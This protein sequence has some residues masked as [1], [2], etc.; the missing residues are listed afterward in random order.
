MEIKLFYSIWKHVE[1]LLRSWNLFGTRE[2]I[3]WAA[4]KTV[5]E[6]TLIRRCPNKHWA[7]FPWKSRSNRAFE[8]IRN[9]W[10]MSSYCHWEWH[11][12]QLETRVC[13]DPKASY[14]P[15]NY[16]GFISWAFWWHILGRVPKIQLVW[17][18]GWALPARLS[19]LLVFNSRGDFLAYHLP[20]RRCGSMLWHKLGQLLQGRALKDCMADLT[21]LKDTSS[22]EENCIQFAFIWKHWLNVSILCPVATVALS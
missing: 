9:M 19:L 16:P 12:Q 1:K 20:S 4:G 6:E 21:A 7:S 14:H 22:A 5:E 15:W 18:E 3:C 11:S 2:N 17:P 10:K 13:K 8:I